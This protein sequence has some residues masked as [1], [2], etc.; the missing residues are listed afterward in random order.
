MDFSKMA[1]VIDNAVGTAIGV[2]FSVY[3]TVMIVFDLTEKRSHG[4]AVICL[5]V[6]MSIIALFNSRKKATVKSFY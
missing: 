4:I 2:Y 3:F 5:C 1:K 6:V